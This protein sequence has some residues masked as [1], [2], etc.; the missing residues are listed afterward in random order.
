[1]KSD[2]DI[3]SSSDNGNNQSTRNITMDTIPDPFTL[4]LRPWPS[5]NPAPGTLRNQILPQI[6]A[7][8]GNFRNISEDILEKEISAAEAEDTAKDN[9]PS[10]DDEEEEEASDPLKE[11]N[12]AKEQM[13]L[14]TG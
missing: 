14:Q 12:A 3:A 10:S 8:R 5:S 2:K 6:H 1:M 9:E 11:L 7:Q 4:S 13:V